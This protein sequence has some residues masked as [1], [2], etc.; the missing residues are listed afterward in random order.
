MSLSPSRAATPRA[1][2][3]P[4]PVGG[5]PRG[6]RLP[7]CLAAALGV[8]A[9]AHAA[10]AGPSVERYDRAHERG[11][12]TLLFHRERFHFA[13]VL[14]A[15]PREQAAR[16]IVTADGRRIHVDWSGR[17]LWI[18]QSKYELPFGAVFLVWTRDSTRVR[19]LEFNAVRDRLLLDQAA[20]APVVLD[21]LRAHGDPQG[22]IVRGAVQADTYPRHTLELTG[23]DCRG[24][25]ALTCVLSGEPLFVLL[26][27]LPLAAG[28][29]TKS[30]FGNLKTVDV[31]V[32]AEAPRTWRSTSTRATFRDR[33]FDLSRG[34]VFLIPSTGEP[35]SQV[36]AG[37]SLG[38]ATAQA[39]ADEIERVPDVRA[40]LGLE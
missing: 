31:L 33:T 20:S 37:L 26:S 15:P 24:V 17:S 18:D 14:D 6:R 27:P 2:P 40:H 35:P 38:H 25:R 29:S 30:F 13:L 36:Q 21:W 34:R 4:A 32:G 28:G 1:L 11:W 22:D 16:R 12:T 10:L 3:T 23:W 5:R 7:A 9:A 8:L 19:Q 39:L